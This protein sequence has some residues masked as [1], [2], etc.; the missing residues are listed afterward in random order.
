ML[1][2]KVQFH[3]LTAYSTTE[4]L[5]TIVDFLSDQAFQHESDTSGSTQCDIDNA[6]ALAITFENG[7]WD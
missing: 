5:D 1:F 3:H 7:S 4:Y 2:L 6:K